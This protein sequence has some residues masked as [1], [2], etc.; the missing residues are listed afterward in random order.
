MIDH[1]EVAL[2]MTGGASAGGFGVTS[3]PSGH[4]V[5]GA[6]RCPAPS[7]DRLIAILG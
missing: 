2:A 7:L 4:E 3:S 5:A 1:H 6:E